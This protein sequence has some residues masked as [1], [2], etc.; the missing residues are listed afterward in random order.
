MY[1]ESCHRCFRMKSLCLCDSIQPFTIEPLIALLV[2]PRE[3][4]KTVGTVRVVKLSL[5][6][7]LMIRGHGKDFDQ[8]PTIASIIENPNH[9]PMIL[10]PGSDSLNLT[11][12]SPEM[13]A[14]QLPN[15]KRL[16]I[17][18]IDGTWSAAKNMIRN[19]QLLNALPRLSFDV[20]CSSIYEFRKQPATYCLSTVEAV[21]V[22]IEN[23]KI[24]N[25][26]TPKP[27]DGHLN[28]IEGFRKLIA[29]QS[30]FEGQPQHRTG[31]R[32]RKGRPAHWGE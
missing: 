26:C 3:F 27:L 2:H 21:S 17:F 23:L 6:G 7:S 9:H 28:M 24:R 13:I 11:T 10:F 16:V 25:L 29:S 32:F 18:V 14:S 15:D 19:S 4:M 30:K 1:R 31:K 5:L 12:A 22:L 8:Y 20:D